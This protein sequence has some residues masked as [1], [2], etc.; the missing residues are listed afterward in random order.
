MIP[1]QLNFIRFNDQKMETEMAFPINF[2]TQEKFARFYGNN[3]VF[4]I[5]GFI[6]DLYLE[7]FQF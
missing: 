3:S 6:F 5:F 4:G 7:F 1:N 2:I